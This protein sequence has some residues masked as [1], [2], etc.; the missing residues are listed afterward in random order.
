M[1]AATHETL[2]IDVLAK[3]QHQTERR[4]LTM[5]EACQRIGIPR[6]TGYD[7]ANAGDFPCRILRI[8]NRWY[9]PIDAIEEMLS[10][11]AA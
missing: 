6:S 7:L 10:G 5:D 1:S 8:G 4:T 3:D 9:V 11:E 2:V